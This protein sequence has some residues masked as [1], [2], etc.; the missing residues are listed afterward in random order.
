MAT[1][2]TI[3]VS[4]LFPFTHTIWQPTCPQDALNE[5]NENNLCSTCHNALCM[6]CQH[7]SNSHCDWDDCMSCIP[8][9]QLNTIY[10]DG[11]GSCIPSTSNPSYIDVEL[12]SNTYGDSTTPHGEYSF[13]TVN[14]GTNLIASNGHG[15]SGYRGYNIVIIN[16]TDATLIDSRSFDVSHYWSDDYAAADNAAYSFLNTYASSKNVQLIA[17]TVEWD[18]RGGPNTFSLIQSMGG[19]TSSSFDNVYPGEA[20]VWIGSNGKTIYCNHSQYNYVYKKIQIQVAI[21]TITHP[22]S[23]SQVTSISTSSTI[24]RQTEDTMEITLQ[25]I[26]D[27]SGPRSK[28]DSLLF[29]VMLVIGGIIIAAVIVGCITL[30]YVKKTGQRVITDIG[31]FEGIHKSRSIEK[32]DIPRDR[33]NL[34]AIR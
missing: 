32:D 20:L 11:S 29:V 7:D 31:N 27:S 5:C 30:F 23:T 9:Y 28:S 16:T 19:C 25:T 2:T 3:C 33:E 22:P 12:Y 34:G 17:V 26:N 24:V 8:G 21:T 4:I 6:Y 1:V 14:N 18:F 13:I 10:T 15:D